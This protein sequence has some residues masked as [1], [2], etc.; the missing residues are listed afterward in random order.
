MLRYRITCD[1]KG[2]Y[3]VLPAATSVVPIGETYATRAEAQD[4]ITSLN[5]R[6]DGG[7]Q[8]GGQAFCVN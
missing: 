5:T 3:V 2:R 6:K 4:T 1:P 8:A 7:R